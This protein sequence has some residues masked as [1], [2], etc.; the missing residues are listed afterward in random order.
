[1]YTFFM[2]SGLIFT[3]LSSILLSQTYNIFPINKLTKFIYPTEETI[4]NKISISIIP[5]LI[6]SLIEIPILA[7]NS[8]FILGIVLNIFLNCSISYIIIYGY[9]LISNKESEIIKII[10]IIISCIFGYFINYISIMIGNDYNMIINIIS[11]VVIIVFYIIIK[12]FP[13]KSEFF[14]GKIE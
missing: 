10:S 2:V 13:P 1:M 4:F 11:L 9:Q 5:I 8:Y 3:I 7:I 12:I 14:R 6:W